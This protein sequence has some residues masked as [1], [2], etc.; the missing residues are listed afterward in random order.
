MS[1]GRG[2]GMSPDAAMECH[3]RVDHLCARL[4][5]LTDRSVVVDRTALDP[6]C[7]PGVGDHLLF[8]VLSGH[9]LQRLDALPDRDHHNLVTVSPDASPGEASDKPRLTINEWH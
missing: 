3:P 9:V 1:P 8:P 2:A 7:F 6:L 5:G 4:R